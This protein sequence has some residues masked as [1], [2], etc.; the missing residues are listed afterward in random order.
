[1]VVKNVYRGSEDKSTKGRIQSQKII[2]SLCLWAS[3]CHLRQKSA[4]TVKRTTVRKRSLRRRQPPHRQDPK[5]RHVYSVAKLLFTQLSGIDTKRDVIP[6]WNQKNRDKDRPFKVKRTKNLKRNRPDACENESIL[7]PLVEQGVKKKKPI[8]MEDDL[9]LLSFDGDHNTPDSANKTK[10]LKENKKNNVLRLS[11]KEL[12]R[13]SPGR[14]WKA[15]TFV[16][17]LNP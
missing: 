2:R 12:K 14:S 16:I 17:M 15:T 7:S 5:L 9:V 10:V 3:T 4:L 1:M 13:K 11:L 8:T 6:K